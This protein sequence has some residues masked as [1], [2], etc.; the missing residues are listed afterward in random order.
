MTDEYL[1]PIVSRY[2]ARVVRSHAGFFLPGAVERVI[3][4]VGAFENY[5]FLEFWDAVEDALDVEYQHFR[6]ATEAH[7]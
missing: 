1:A 3:A 5:D 6:N 2:I 4:S 7:L